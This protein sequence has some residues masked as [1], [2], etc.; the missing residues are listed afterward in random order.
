GGRTH[1][2]RLRRKVVNRAP[3][4]PAVDA[5]AAIDA[6]NP[7]LDAF[8][9]RRLTRLRRERA[10]SGVSPQFR[11]T[12]GRI[13]TSP[14]TRPEPTAGRHIPPFASGAFVCSFES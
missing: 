7:P 4:N 10:T 13:T 5:F 6:A 2:P 1:L 12:C 9:A 8:A 11:R 3:P 14:E